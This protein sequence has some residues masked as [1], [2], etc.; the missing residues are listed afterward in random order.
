MKTCRNLWFIAVAVACLIGL[1]GTIVTVPL[2]L[3]L[4]TGVALAAFGAL[5]A[6]SFKEDLADVRHP[7]LW[8]AALAI[9]PALV[10]GLSRV[11]GDATLPVVVGLVVAS[12]WI[13]A[14]A[15]RRLRQW[16]RP[17]SIV[18]AGMAAPDEA[19][20]RQWEESTRQLGEAASVADRLVVVHVREQILDDVAARHGGQLPAFV[21][22]R[23]SPVRDFRP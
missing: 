12:P 4:W 15:Q 22:D 7:L 9:A 8:G 20:R 3:V 23:P 5:M 14:L 18:R 2:S 10:P 1:G 16:L 17:A 6:L 11:L 19:L 21:W 13:V